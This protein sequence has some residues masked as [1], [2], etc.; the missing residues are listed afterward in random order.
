MT[1]KSRFDEAARKAMKLGQD[2]L[3]RQTRMLITDL[4]ADPAR[5]DPKRLQ[6][7]GRAG[8]AIF[9][10]AITQRAAERAVPSDAI[11]PRP[12]RLPQGWAAERRR[13]IGF[14]TRAVLCGVAGG[15]LLIIVPPLLRLLSL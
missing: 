14:M 2:E 10:E 13:E 6:T 5:F 9:Y 4:E 1:R 7:L 15:L 3:Q 11:E 12:A 8:L